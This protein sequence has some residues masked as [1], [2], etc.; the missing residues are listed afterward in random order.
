[1]KINNIAENTAFDLCIL[2]PHA[3]ISIRVI[4]EIDNDFNSTL[5]SIY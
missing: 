2:V 5:K 3:I 1:V 4:I